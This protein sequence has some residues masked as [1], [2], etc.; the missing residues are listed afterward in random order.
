[1]SRVERAGFEGERA[2]ADSCM[3]VM[4]SPPEPEAKTSVHAYSLGFDIQHSR[5][6]LLNR[7]L[8]LCR[9][10]PLQFVLA[11]CPHFSQL[12]VRE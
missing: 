7:L 4:E 11:R 6:Q 8:G 9:W 10:Q 12:L 1:M 5:P 2:L 3:A